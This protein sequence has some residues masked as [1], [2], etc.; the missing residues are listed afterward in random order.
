MSKHL[1]PWLP[2]AGSWGR[3]RVSFRRLKMASKADARKESTGW[4]IKRGIAGGIVA[5][6]VMLIFE[7]LSTAFMGMSPFMPPRMMAGIV[8]GPTAMEDSFSLVAALAVSLTLHMVLSAAYGMFFAVL[9]RAQGQG[10][11]GWAMWLEASLF[12]LGLWLLNFYVF[13]PTFGWK[14]FPEGANPVQQFL[15]HTF[16]FGTVL[17]IYIERAAARTRAFQTA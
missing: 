6:I 11:P 10:L 8:V 9:V 15:A 16:A 17:G 13:A 5:G 7:M 12:G 1:T 2:Q 3:V 4:W 14:W